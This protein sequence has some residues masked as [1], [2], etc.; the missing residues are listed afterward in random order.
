MHYTDGYK[1]KYFDGGVR[2]CQTDK[3]TCETI[4]HC[5]KYESLMRLQVV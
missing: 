3:Q 5:P 1:L 2:V 4:M